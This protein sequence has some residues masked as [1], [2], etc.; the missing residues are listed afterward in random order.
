MNPSSGLSAPIASNSRSVTSR[1]LSVMAGREAAR[2]VKASASAPDISSSFRRPPCG[3]TSPVVGSG[4]GR[5]LLRGGHKAML[6]QVGEDRV[7]RLL[8]A[9]GLRVDPHLGLLGRL[10]GV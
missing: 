8:L 6:L 3:A 1:A 7:E 2:A 9:L 10:V 4:T 5:L